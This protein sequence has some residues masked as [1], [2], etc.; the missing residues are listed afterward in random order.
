MKKLLTI[1]AAATLCFGS[2]VHAQQRAASAEGG[3]SAEM[4]SEISKGYVGD[5]KD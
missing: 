1:V 4:L 5:A 3:I 2:A